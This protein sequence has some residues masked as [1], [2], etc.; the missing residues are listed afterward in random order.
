MLRVNNLSFSYDKSTAFQFPDFELNDGDSLLILG[1]SGCGKSTLLHL[2]GGLLN[3]N[4]GG[5]QLDGEEYSSLKGKKLDQFRGQHIGI[6]FQQH[7]F[8]RSLNMYDNLQ[9]SAYLAK[10]KISDE[11]I[12]AIAQQMRIEHLLDK[13][14]YTLS[15][16]QQQRMAIARSVINKPKLLLADEPTSSLDDVNST[17]VADLLQEQAKLTGAHLILV[18]HDHRVADRFNRVIEL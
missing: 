11:E 4:T 10:K 9:M 12:K 7:H 14:S 16:G 6:V 8:V 5:V 18:T 17:K 13:K 3:P 1:A 15:I 2:L